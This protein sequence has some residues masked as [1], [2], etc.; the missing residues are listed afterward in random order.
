MSHQQEQNARQPGIGL[1]FV[2]ALASAAGIALAM[3][4]YAAYEFWHIPGLTVKQLFLHHLSHALLLGA[5]IHLATWLALKFLLSR[6]LD[7]IY[8]HLYGVGEGKL[9]PLK[10]ETRIR[11]IK[12]IVDGIN[13]MIWRIGRSQDAEAF[14]K[15]EQDLLHLKDAI[16]RVTAEN[17]ALLADLTDS[18]ENL[19]RSLL[20]LSQE[21]P[22]AVV[23]N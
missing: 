9:Q 21:S 11:E 3:A 14:A 10:I 4:A 20:S 5:V 13:L 23:T 19:E 8:V 22:T 17:P 6:Q 12:L 15:A 18:V 7:Q 1:S 2:V 16:K